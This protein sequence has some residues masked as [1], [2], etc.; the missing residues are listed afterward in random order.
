MNETKFII[1]ISQLANEFPIVIVY[2]VL[3]ISGC[4]MPVKSAD[5][6]IEKDWQHYRGG[7]DRIVG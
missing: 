2:T 7:R 4:Y 1:L 6:R 5:K 3:G